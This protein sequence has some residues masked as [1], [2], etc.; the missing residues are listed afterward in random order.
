MSHNNPTI[1]RAPLT[2]IE[3]FN[4]YHAWNLEHAHQ[5]KLDKYRIFQMNADAFE[6]RNHAFMLEW[7]GTNYT[8]ITTQLLR[9]SM[10][11]FLLSFRLHHASALA[12]VLMKPV[13]ETT[14]CPDYEHFVDGSN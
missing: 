11:R 14:G 6:Q 10:H 1:C 3:Q 4:M 2:A 13:N 8:I 7:C 5:M 12:V 9:P